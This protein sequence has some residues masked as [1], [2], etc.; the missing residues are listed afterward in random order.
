MKPLGWALIQYNYVGKEKKN[1]SSIF[2]G[3]VTRAYELNW[4]KKN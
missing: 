4:Q 3:L 1:I 2:L